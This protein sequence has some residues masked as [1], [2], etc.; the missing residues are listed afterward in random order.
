MLSWPKLSCS[1]SW[2]FAT[3]ALAFLLH[4]GYQTQNQRSVVEGPRIWLPNH[5]LKVSRR[6]NLLLHWLVP[7]IFNCWSPNQSVTEVYI[8]STLLWILQT[9]CKTLLTLR[10]K[11]SYSLGFYCWFPYV[12]VGLVWSDINDAQPNKGIYLLWMPLYYE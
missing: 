11:P 12:W 5:W 2:L 8:T 10:V 6:L 7:H 4:F 9:W 3:L 1:L